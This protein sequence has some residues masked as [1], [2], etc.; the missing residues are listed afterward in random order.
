LV[1]AVSLAVLA[2]S[3]AVLMMSPGRPGG[4]P[5]SAFGRRN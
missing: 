2:V 5:S 3:S 4:G 1:L